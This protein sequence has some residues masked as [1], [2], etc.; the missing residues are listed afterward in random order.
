MVYPYCHL[1]LFPFPLLS[2]TEI[3]STRISLLNNIS[4]SKCNLNLTTISQAMDLTSDYTPQSPGKYYKKN[5][6]LYQDSITQNQTR[7]QAS[8][9]F[10]GPKGSHKQPALRVT[11]QGLHSWDEGG[12]GWKEY[13]A[14]DSLWITQVGKDRQQAKHQQPN[15]P[16]PNFPCRKHTALLCYWALFGS[17]YRT[18]S[19]RNHWVLHLEVSTGSRAGP[20]SS[21][22]VKLWKVCMGSRDEGKGSTS[23]IPPPRSQNTTSLEGSGLPDVIE[24][25]PQIWIFQ[26]EWPQWSCDSFS[27]LTEHK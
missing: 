25:L 10:K 9:S 16:E 1:F 8:A 26:V 21:W 5:W 11:S 15:Q 17:F 14:R 4:F 20:A 19:L 24:V 2:K 6:C 27:N 7:A 13:G 23:A 18:P 12:E 22:T 3:N